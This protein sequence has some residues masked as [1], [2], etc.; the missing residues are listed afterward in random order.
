MKLILYCQNF[1]SNQINPI[2]DN[3]EFLYRGIIEHF[4]DFE[5][6]RPS[7]AIFKDSKGVSVDRDIARNEND[8]VEFLQSKKDFFAI[9]KIQTKKVRELDA[10]AKYLPVEGNIYHSEIHDSESRVQMRGSKPKKLRG[11]CVVVYKK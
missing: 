10:I 11:N 2:I 3:N 9:C 6:N 7:S 1:M 5:N 8:C 4:W